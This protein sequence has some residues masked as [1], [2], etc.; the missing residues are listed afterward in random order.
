MYLSM[1]GEMLV[2]PS[3]HEIC[4]TFEAYIGASRP[5]F[6]AILDQF[7]GFTHCPSNVLHVILSDISI[8][9]ACFKNLNDALLTN[10]PYL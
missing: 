2:R 10:G 8:K 1:G 3:V 9:R 7:C 5:G 6:W 4:S